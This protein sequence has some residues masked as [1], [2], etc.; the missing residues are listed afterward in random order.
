MPHHGHD[1]SNP[2]AETPLADALL[3]LTATDIGSVHALPLSRGHVLEGSRLQEKYLALFGKAFLTSDVS[4]SSPV[5]DSLFRPRTCLAAAQRLAAQAFGADRTFFVTCGTTMSNTIALSAMRLHGR[6]VLVDRTTH[7]SVH[8]GLDR[9]GAEVT[10]AGTSTPSD[11]GFGQADV[12]ALLREFAV[13]ARAGTPY[14][15]VVLSGSSYDGRL[16]DLP[17]VLASLMEHVTEL[18]VLVDEAW[19]ALYSFHPRLAS[20]T[21]LAAGRHVRALHPDRR[22]RLFVTHSAHKSMAALRQGSYL[23]V[24]G[25]QDTIER[26]EQ[27]LYS[28]HTTSPSLPILASLDLARSQA[29]TEGEAL[30]DRCL[31][32]AARL[33]L[34]LQGGAFPGLVESPSAPA[35]RWMSPDPAKVV[36]DAGGLGLS[37]QDLRLRLFHDHGLY[38]ARGAGTKLL[39]NLHAGVTPTVM[40]RLERALADLAV[41]DVAPVDI[42]SAFLVPYP[43]GVPLTVPGEAPENL[44]ATVAGFLRSGVDVF[45]VP[46]SGAARPAA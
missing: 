1:P 6:R 10:Y 22:L 4:F 46:Q 17:A 43:P 5:I 21:A 12:E 32:H 24:L 33:R 28:L 20:R 34:L 39:L 13:A 16:L 15:A 36:V 31:L 41:D 9:S 25:D 42:E 11:D 19:T 29:A 37:A 38:A 18:D 7:Q 8:F 27:A 23:H 35:S 2:Q 14:Q 26:V 3:R 40:D 30:V 45:A 44:A